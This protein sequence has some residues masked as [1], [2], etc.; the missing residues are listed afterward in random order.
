MAR[1]IENS[2]ETEL[3]NERALMILLD[4]SNDAAK[5]LLDAAIE[6]MHE[7]LEKMRQHIEDENFSG[8]LVDAVNARGVA[9]AMMSRL[10]K[11]AADKVAAMAVLQNIEEA[12]TSYSDMCR[13]LKRF[14]LH[15]RLK[16]WL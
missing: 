10:I 5:A 12:K 8:I 14:E 1:Q 6:E 4:D 3:F 15:L 11:D 7:T 9:G 13:S 2:I 16:G